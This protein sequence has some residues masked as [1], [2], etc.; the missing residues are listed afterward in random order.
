MSKNKLEQKKDIQNNL[1]E[2]P[3]A[4]FFDFNDSTIY[5]RPLNKDGI[6]IVYFN[7]DCEHCQYEISEIVSSLNMFKKYLIIFISN[8]NKRNTYEFGRKYM[9]IG[10]NN[11][12]LLLDNS[13]LFYNFFGTTRVP[14]IFVYNK[15]FYLKSRFDGEIKL[16]KVIDVL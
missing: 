9:L 11:I 15:K 1:K 14:T 2:M 16:Q 5:L 12:K 7:P 4:F 10:K 13:N 6:V 8:E 3:D